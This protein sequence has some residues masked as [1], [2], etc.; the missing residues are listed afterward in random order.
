MALF[1][2]ILF[3]NVHRAFCITYFFDGKLDSA[4]LQDISLL[5]FV[6]DLL[7]VDF[8][9]THH[10]VHA[11]LRLSISLDQ[12][13]IFGVV[14]ISCILEV[15]CVVIAVNNFE[16]GHI[17]GALH[18]TFNLFLETQFVIILVNREF[19][20]GAHDHSFIRGL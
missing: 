15:E 1:L 5:N 8:Q 16:H 2:I 11:L 9:T 4:N 3:V 12:L 17:I 20:A 14:L 13:K 6:I 10:Q 18:N 7:V 19:V